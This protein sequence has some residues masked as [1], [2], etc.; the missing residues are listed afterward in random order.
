MTVQVLVS[1][2]TASLALAT[3]AITGL[4]SS[5][6]RRRLTRLQ[7]DLTRQ[8]EEERKAQQHRDLMS[9]YH[10]PLLWAAFD[11]QSRLY[12][13]DAQYFLGAYFINGSDEEK[14]YARRNTVFLLAEYLGWMEIIR[15]G[16]QFLDLGQKENN[17]QLVKNLA[18]ISAVL[19]SDRDH[20]F[21]VFHGEQR[22][23]GELMIERKENDDRVDGWGCIGYAQ[24][25]RKLDEDQEFSRWFG[26]LLDSV[27][28]LAAPMS[29]RWR[30]VALQNA[31][32]DLIDF[33]D[34]ESIRF[35][36]RQ[37]YRLT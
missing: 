6:D 29:C 35:P 16:V 28:L 36:A 12:N 15:Q 30:L 24:F 22:A 37:R 1:L 20:V 23:I 25:C 17:R 31:L 14:S 2:V 13:I 8:R 32:I 26:Q 3:A 4:L 9:Q 27:E 5:W 19:T 33:L 11:L 7:D 18:K 10:D 21:R 34:P